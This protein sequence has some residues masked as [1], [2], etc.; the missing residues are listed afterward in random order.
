CF[1]LHRQYV[2]W[3]EAKEFCEQQG[4]VL[5][6]LNSKELLE[7]IRFKL[8]NGHSIP[9]WV[10]AIESTEKGKHTW[11]SNNET[12]KSSINSNAF[13]SSD[14]YKLRCLSIK[15]NKIEVN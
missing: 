10:G 11:I 6:T 15:D 14:M 13:N 1:T 8:E 7:K 2:T 4:S 9:A 3:Y 5:A 12:V